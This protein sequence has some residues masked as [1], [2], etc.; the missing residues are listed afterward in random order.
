MEENVG[1]YTKEECSIPAGMG[2]YIPVQTNCEI[3]GDVLIKISDKTVM[4]L[5]LPEIVYNVKK[6][7]GCIFIENHNSEPLELKREQMIGKVTPCIVTQ[8]EQGQLLKKLKEDMQSV[9]G[10]SNDMDTRICG[11][12]GEN[13]EKAGRKAGSVQSIENRQFYERRKASIYQ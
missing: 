1:V 4:G 13:A 9:T 3:K 11:A 6:K 12:S 8:A 5:I 7:L 2:K 10:W